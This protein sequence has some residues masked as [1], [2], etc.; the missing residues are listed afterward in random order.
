MRQI[1]IAVFLLL[2]VPA[3]VLAE[4]GAGTKSEQTFFQADG[5]TTRSGHQSH[6]ADPDTYVTESF[7]IVDGAWEPRRKYVWKRQPV[8][9]E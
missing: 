6:F 7:D 3:L 8:D 5:T 9:K 1:A 2:S 4:D